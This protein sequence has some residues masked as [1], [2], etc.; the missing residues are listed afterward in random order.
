M[1]GISH[2]PHLTIA[3]KVPWIQY[4]IAVDVGTAQRDLITHVALAHPQIA[5]RRVPRLSDRANRIRELGGKALAIE[6]DVTDEAQTSGM[7]Q[8][9]LQDF[10]RLDMLFNVAGV[11]VAAPFQNTTTSDYRL[12]IDV[13]YLG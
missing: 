6:A 7:V 9:V 12:M 8:R 10:G 5:A 11:G 3:A 4:K 1:T 13:N 2:L